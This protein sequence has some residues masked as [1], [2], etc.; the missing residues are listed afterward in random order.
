MIRI[1]RFTEKQFASMLNLT[2]TVDFQEE[3]DGAKEI[4]QV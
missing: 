3:I 1:L 4:I 2:E